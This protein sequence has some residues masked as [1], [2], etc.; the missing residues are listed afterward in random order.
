MG[1]TVSSSLPEDWITVDMVAQYAYCPRRFHL[2]YVEGYWEDNV[3]TLEGKDIHRRVDRYQDL[4][5]E[6]ANSADAAT[7]ERPPDGE[8]PPIVARSVS[9]GS[10]VLKVMGKLD[11]VSADPEAGEAIPVETKKGRVPNNPERSYEPERIQLM[12]QGLLLRAHG[13]SSAHGY[14]Y[15]AASRQ[16]VRIE[17]T[18]QLEEQTRILISD[19]SI[20]RGSRILPPPLDDSPKC[21][22]CSLCGIRLPDETSLL[23]HSPDPQER[24]PSDSDSGPDV[25]RLFAAREHATPFYVQEQ[26][27]RIGKSA[28][29]L[30]VVGRDGKELG[31]AKLID[32]SQVVVMG[33]VQIS[34][35][36]LHLLMEHEKPV[37]H[38]STGGW[39]HGI[40]HGPGLGHAYSRHGQYQCA[41]DA[42]RCTAF[43]RQL[44]GAK[45][46]NQRVLLLRNGRTA[47]ARAT[48][49]RMASLIRDLEATGPQDCDALLGWEGRGAALYFSAFQDMLKTGEFPEFVFTARN[50]R[51]PRDPVNALLSFAYALLAKECTAALIGEGLDPWWGLLHQPRHGRPSLALDLMEPFRPVIAD[52][53]VITVINTGMI[54]HSDF[55]SNANGCA[56]MPSAKK[57]LL[58]AWEQRLDQLYT[59]PAFDYRCS[60]RTMLRIQAR[61]LVRWLRK[62]IPTWPC[63]V[64]R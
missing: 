29:R 59:H 18:S 6:S 12:V 33:N 44:I 20:A 23:R 25:R 64:I 52:S 21:W 61:L 28:E 4:L 49:I 17:F 11:L 45:I 54:K 41:A 43:A 9:L 14:V 1:Q 5:P 10:D 26:G 47:H 46:Q 42:E 3:H 16:R 37:V 32:I 38:F 13:Y 35:Q 2:M 22:G 60:W 55:T 39:F 7:L 34:A 63:P 36:A 15:Y 48:V 53:V 62:D 51:P 31:S 57:S 8:D 19:V 24:P 40:S 56:L 50:R 27:A 58:K 30:N